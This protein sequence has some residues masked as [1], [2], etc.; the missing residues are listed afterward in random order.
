VRQGEGDSTH[1]ALPP[2]RAA[3]LP[4]FFVLD[5]AFLSLQQLLAGRYSIERELGRGGMGIVLLARD[6]PLDR[7]VAIK[8]LPP[9]LAHDP[10]VRERFLREA[11]TA[12]G[13]SHPHIVPIHAVEELGEWVF[14]VMGYVDGETLRERVERSG[15]IGPRQALK[16]MQEA[17]W[18]LGYAHERGVVHRDVKPDNIMV[19]RATDRTVVMDFGIAVVGK[20]DEAGEV[21]GTARYMSPE[22]ACGEAVDGRSDLYSL[23]ATIFYALVGRPPFEA[24]NVPALLALHV[25]A[26]APA[27]R[28]VRAEV[29]DR[30][31]AVID[32][33]LQKEPADRFGS[34]EELSTQVE[35]VRGRQMRSPPL[36]RGFMRNAQVSTMVFLA[37]TVAGQ[38]VTV[39]EGAVSFSAGGPGLIGMILFIQ[40]VIVARRLLREGYAFDDIRTALLAEAHAQ[41]E[42]A[43]AA[44]QGRWIRRLDG[45]WQRIWAGRFGRW[46]FRVAGVGVGA[47]ARPALPSADRTELVLGRSVAEAYG[48]L[49]SEQRDAVPSL[50]AVV[51]RLEA[52]AARLRERGESGPALTDTVAALEHVR[53]A[54]LR[55]RSGAGSVQD[56]TAYLDRAREIGERIDLEIAVRHEMRDEMRGG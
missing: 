27:V 1:A 54:L 29:P 47:P 55:L 15:P 37:A 10:A 25:S 9:E 43:D 13:L 18:A 30:L 52:R 42:E 19:E 45:L 5:P 35:V 2:C 23:G 8:L 39:T 48:D 40:L 24:R 21:I 4:P 20:P 12:A 26:P 34:G 33:L 50:P 11:R 28:S 36:V 46:F 14:F 3:A 16:V 22:Q 7:L 6:V 44:R 51:Q 49:T 32:R 38:G 31:A 41:E 53:L 17:A 56:L